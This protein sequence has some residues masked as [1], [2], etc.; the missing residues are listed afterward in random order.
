MAIAKSTDSLLQRLED[1]QGAIS[2]CRVVVE[3]IAVDSDLDGA[4]DRFHVS[5]LFLVESQLERTA[6][7]VTEIV[8]ELMTSNHGKEGAA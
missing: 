4:G 6:E 1:I 2:G 7:R 3:Q 5:S 8:S